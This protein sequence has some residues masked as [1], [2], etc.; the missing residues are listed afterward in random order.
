MSKKEQTALIIKGCKFESS[1]AWLISFTASAAAFDY[2]IAN[3]CLNNTTII[4]MKK[5]EK[6]CI[7]D[8]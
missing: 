7:W 1:L 8:C 6:D 5:Q 3:L 2:S 4:H